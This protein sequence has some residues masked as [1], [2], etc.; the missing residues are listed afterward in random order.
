[1]RIKSLRKVHESCQKCQINATN[2]PGNSQA[3]ASRL[4][5]CVSRVNV[6][7][8]NQELKWAGV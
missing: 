7:Q 6:T 4:F 3:L 5:L 2:C 1:M 8:S